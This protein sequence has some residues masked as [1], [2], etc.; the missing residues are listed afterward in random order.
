MYYLNYTYLHTFQLVNLVVV[1]HTHDATY[2]NKEQ[3]KCVNLKM[4]Y[5]N[6][7]HLYRSIL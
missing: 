3:L 4:Y 1:G 2:L 7:T 5:L 6:Y